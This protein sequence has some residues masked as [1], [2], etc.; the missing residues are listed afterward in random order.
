VVDSLRDE[1]RHE[2][3][4]AAIGVLR[5][6][7]VVPLSDGPHHSGGGVVLIVLQQQASAEDDM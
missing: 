4:S 1:R 7:A 5:H 6:E 3:D 2:D